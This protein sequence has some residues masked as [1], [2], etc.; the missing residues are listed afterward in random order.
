M[1][2]TLSPHTILSKLEE[3]KCTNLQAELATLIAKRDQLVAELRAATAR[4]EEIENRRHKPSQHIVIASELAALEM[5]RHEEAARI[6]ELSRQLSELSGEEK[7]LKAEAF[8]CMSKSNAYGSLQ[9]KEKKLQERLLS[10]SKQQTVDD[11]MAHRR[12]QEN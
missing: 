10:R 11:L 2:N 8:A 1:S 6:E 4:L 7:R 12:I 3:N 5:A 9:D